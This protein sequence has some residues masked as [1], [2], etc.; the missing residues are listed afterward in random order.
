MRIGKITQSAA[1]H[2][3]GP[4]QNLDDGLTQAQGT[5]SA[6]ATGRGGGTDTG[7]IQGFTGVDVAHTDHDVTGQQDLF[8]G[9]S[10]QP[11]SGM[12]R[13]RIEIRPQRFDTQAA[14]QFHCPRIIQIRHMNQRT[15]SSRIV[16]TQGA[17]IGHQIGMVM[18]AW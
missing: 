17:P 18:R 6:D 15:K 10:T 2:F 8:D 7:H 4:R 1:S 16:Q 9:G 13:L 3:Q 12:K 11:Q 5:G 14:Q